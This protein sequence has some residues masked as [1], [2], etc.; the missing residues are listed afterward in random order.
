MILKKKFSFKN[1][2]KAYA[3]V[4]I[5]LKLNKSSRKLHHVKQDRRY[6]KKRIEF[7]R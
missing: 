6:D 4:H 3:L 7:R 2:Y 1:E 5:E